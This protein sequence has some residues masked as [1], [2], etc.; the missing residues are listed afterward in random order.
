MTKN[1]KHFTVEEA[2]QLLPTLVPILENMVEL[3]EQVDKLEV[4]IDSLELILG[5]NAKD[6]KV[7]QELERKISELNERIGSLS[8]LINKVES[9][10]CFLKSIESGLIDFLS[11]KDGRTIYLC[12]RLGEPEIKHWHEIGQGFTNRQPI[13]E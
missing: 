1:V 3:R 7:S 5:N 6:N 8:T 13:T 12:W 11:Q 2:N 10:G 9:F 4:E